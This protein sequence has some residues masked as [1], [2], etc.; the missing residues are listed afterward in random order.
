MSVD[1][2]R[3]GRTSRSGGPLDVLEKVLQG[4]GD[5][6]VL[7]KPVHDDFGNCIR[8]DAAIWVVGMLHFADCR[9][10]VHL[11]MQGGNSQSCA[12]GD[13]DHEYTHTIDQRV[14]QEVVEFGQLR[15][16]QMMS[17]WRGH[18]GGGGRN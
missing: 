12:M 15:E 5:A 7:D 18:R 10:V 8:L 16:R 1:L 2:H 3:G 6:L 4:C 11:V 17:L 13:L 9:P 14:G